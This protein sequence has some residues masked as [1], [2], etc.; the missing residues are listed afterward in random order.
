MYD[1][2]GALLPTTPIRINLAKENVPKFTDNIEFILTGT[3]TCNG[4]PTSKP[5]L[6]T[7]KTLL[8]VVVLHGYVTELDPLIFPVKGIPKIP[9]MGYPGGHTDA[10]SCTAIANVLNY[11]GLFYEVAYKNFS[12]NLTE[13]K[14]SSSKYWGTNTNLKN[15][16]TLWDPS[17]PDIGYS[18]LSF[19][20][21]SNILADM[22]RVYSLVQEYSYAAKFNIVGHS[23]G[24]LAARLWAFE[25]SE[26]INKVITVGTPHEG[27]ARFYESVFQNKI[28]NRTE[29]ELQ[30]LR[31]TP[32]GKIP[33]TLAWFVPRNDYLDYWEAIDWSKIPERPSDPSMDPYF[34]NSFTYGYSS[35]V[36]YDL[37]YGLW[38][39]KEKG[40][41]TGFTTPYSTIIKL[42][43]PDK[44]YD[45]A[46]YSKWYDF[47]GYNF[48]RGDG[49]VYWKSAGNIHGPL[50]SNI[51]R[52]EVQEIM[53][54][55]GVILN[56]NGVRAEILDFLH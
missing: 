43:V 18:S 36:K 14:Y 46:T 53:N 48:D 11:R 52:T 25:H 21:P 33:N 28:D 13:N 4:G 19:A 16:V 6:I 30:Y 34:S 41:I 54:T 35:D 26:R 44:K 1:I 3:A 7:V 5:S 55:H 9:I 49:Y 37:I 38:N 8:P 15:Y 27:I 2:K 50:S 42:R 23:T 22:D 45:P 40:R 51:K 20:T 31:T 47:V 12:K 39:K 17:D 29:F 56:N 32:G 10:P 24:G